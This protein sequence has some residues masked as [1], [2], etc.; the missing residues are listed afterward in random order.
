M[1]QVSRSTARRFR[2]VCRKAV[3]SAS[4][5]QR[6]AA[7]VLESGR[8]GLV[9]RSQSSQI[10]VELRVPGTFEIGRLAIPL[11][12]SEQFEGRDESPV[13]LEAA[14]RGKVVARWTDGGVPQTAEFDA[15]DLHTLPEFP[16]QPATWTSN[17]PELLRALCDASAA[18]DQTSTRYALHM[19]QLR[20]RAGAVVGTDGRQLFVGSG[21]NF[22][23]ADDLLVP[24]VAFFACREF[25]GDAAVEVGQTKGFVVVRVAHWTVHLRVDTE[26]RFPEVNSI[27]PDPNAAL[28]T[29]RMS[30]DDAEFLARTLPRLPS[31]HE[32]DSPVTIDCDGS[33]AVRASAGG[34]TPPTELVLARSEVAGQSVR[35]ANNR[36]YLAHA[37]SLGFREF[38]L[39]G[40]GLLTSCHDGHRQYLWMGLSKEAIVSPADN[41]VRITSDAVAKPGHSNGREPKAATDGSPPSNG[42]GHGKPTSRVAAKKGHGIAAVIDEA[43]GLKTV[44]RDAYR[45]SSQLVVS[46]RR[47]RTQAKLMRSTIAALRQLAP[48]ER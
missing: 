26:G 15:V 11:D 29:I 14:A 46:L 35:C 2:A 22:P 45:R 44:L 25:A 43:Q 9:F 39:F 48:I 16:A 19:I 13:S 47:H 17:G 23:F 7:V 32:S 36:R 4:L 20:G 31:S 18:A 40:P 5:P 38:R 12:A 42:K 27:V 30:P 41:A 3:L 8:E 24:R 10:A 34:Q 1:I 6:P 28:A 37:L 33:V 21:F